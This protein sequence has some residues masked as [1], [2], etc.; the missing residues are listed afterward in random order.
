MYITKSGIKHTSHVRT[1]VRSYVHTSVYSMCI[2]GMQQLS[3]VQGPL[4]HFGDISQQAF[5]IQTG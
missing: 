2:H 4:L 5:R 1:Y 3:E